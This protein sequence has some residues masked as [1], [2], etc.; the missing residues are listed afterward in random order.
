MAGPITERVDKVQQAR[1]SRIQD[2]VKVVFASSKE[3]DLVQS[4]A[5]NLAKHSGTN[6]NGVARAPKRSVQV[7]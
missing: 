4:Y 3:R 7:V 1:R 5:A 6:P 2:E